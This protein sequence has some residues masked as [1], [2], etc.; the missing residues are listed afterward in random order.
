M[1][2]RTHV[3]ARLVDSRAELIL[4][5]HI[6]QAAVSERHEF[7]VIAGDELGVV[8]SIAPGLGQPRP[9]PPD[10]TPRIRAYQAWDELAGSARHLSALRTVSADLA[11]AA[12]VEGADLVHSHTWYANLAGHMAKLLYGVPHVVTVHSLE[13]LRPWKAEQLGG[14]YQLSGFCERTGL[15]GADAV[16]AVSEGMRRDVLACYPEI[17]PGR[18][19][20]IHNGIDP[21]AYRPAPSPAA[22]RAR[23][24]DPDRPYAIF[25][26]RVTRQKGLDHLL[27]AAL[28][29][30]RRYQVVVCAGTRAPAPSLEAPEAAAAESAAPT[31]T[32]SG[33]ARLIAGPCS[34]PCRTTS[35]TA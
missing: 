16:I 30:D 22:V 23:G 34:T 9:Q 15:L 31:R 7:E 25:V 24:I 18:V 33:S 6:H 20:V 35:R 17:E 19:H 14:G 5:G 27:R 28:L 10:G 4:G 13:P 32:R 12:G 1:A 21:A 8:V 29:V 3:L 11:I 2:R 26:G